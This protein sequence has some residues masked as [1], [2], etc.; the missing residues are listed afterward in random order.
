MRGKGRLLA[1]MAATVMLLTAMAGPVAARD[2]DVQRSGACSGNSTWKLKAGPRDGMIKVEFEVDQN[3]V[4]KTWRVRLSD[5]GTIFFRG[6]R[7]TQAPSGSFTVNRRT[8][9][10]AGTDKIVAFARNLN[11]GETC[12]GVV[13]IG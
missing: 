5:N 4:G 13:R 3:K 12:R 11:S 1:A 7:V 10:L 2:G 9:D 8:T 6:L